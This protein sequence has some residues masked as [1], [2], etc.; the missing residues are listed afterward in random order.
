MQIFDETHDEYLSE[1][2]CQCTLTTRG[3]ALMMAVMLGRKHFWSWVEIL[4]VITM[5]NKL[6]DDDVL[7]SSKFHL[8]KNFPLAE[9]SFKYH[10]FCPTC[11]RYIGER[12][13]LKFG[14]T[15]NC[16]SCDEEFN[17]T[18]VSSFFV[19]LNFKSQV[20]R[21]LNNP[22]IAKVLDYRFVRKKNGINTLNDIYDGAMYRK[23]AATKEFSSCP[24]NLSYTF[25]TDG[26]Q[27][28]N[29]SNVSI[30]PVYAMIHELPPKLRSKN[31]FLVGLWVHKKE[32]NMNTFLRPFVDEAN[33]L[34]EEGVQWTFNG[35]LV[36]SKVFPICCC[37]DSVARPGMLCMNRF[38]GHFGCNFCEHPTVGIEGYRKYVMTTE[39]PPDRTD[40]SIRMAMERS[41]NNEIAPINNK[42]VKGPSVLMNLK[43]FD[44]V[45]GMV[46]DYLHSVLLGVTKQYT[47][48][49]LT[50]YGKNYYVG[51]PNQLA[52]INERLLSF[53]PPTCITRSPRPIE[54]RRN[55]KASEWRSW[56][57][58]YI[59][60]CLRGLLPEKYLH[61]T[62]LLVTAI[63]TLL[64][65]S[66][67]NDELVDAHTLLVKFVVQFQTYFGKCNMTFNIHLLLH[68]SDSVK[69]WGP[70][71]THNAFCFENENR[72]VLQM[73]TSPHL[74]A[75]QIAR[76]FLF[77]KQLSFHC[78]KFPNGARFIEFHNDITLK[79]LKF[80]CKLNECTLLGSG[81]HYI[82][83]AE[84]TACF[85]RALVC[86]IYSKMIFRGHRYTSQMYTR[87]NKSDD[88]VIHTR[89]NT[90][91]IITNICAYDERVGDKVRKK[92]I[93]FLRKLHVSLEPYIR[94]SNVLVNHIRECSI[95]INRLLKC[96]PL[97]LSGHC[98]L[99]KV[100]EKYYVSDV[101][102]GCLGD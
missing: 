88:S 34:V 10:L 18:S 7:P 40:Q 62:A 70:L 5:M 49:I 53:K 46:P 31:M 14:A 66:I 15:V 4:D 61:H 36:T 64:Q 84:E 28:A 87:A 9:D 22:D 27:A 32:P 59:L 45:N 96:S 50:S 13:K 85:G 47:E 33:S 21:L 55:W 44:L 41:L 19:T 102:R 51:A 48:L 73:K 74:I 8:F 69:N 86:K 52:V 35:E 2:L 11:E 101:P 25:N 24:F 3:E 57:V 16:I 90:R 77:Y 37:V 30:W 67:S 89:D 80:S 99:M 58:W 83:N 39:V 54:E 1:K 20:L 42:G 65:E 56:L 68:L 81:K 79:Q 100:N 95:S 78:D 71:W 26:C 6:Y 17:E 63:Q 82:L 76:R 93:I 98:I 97:S 72:L 92:I 75:I 91:G 38:N 94:T 23:L 60:I 12:S 29:S 43:G